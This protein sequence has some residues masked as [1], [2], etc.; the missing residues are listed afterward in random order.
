[1]GAPDQLRFTFT[2]S[3]QNSTQIGQHVSLNYCALIS[4]RL[5][6]PFQQ[7]LYFALISDEI[8]VGTRI[9]SL[10]RPCS[11]GFVCLQMMV[12]ELAEKN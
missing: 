4:G 8:G 7:K 6:C 2:H 1:M 12:P 11:A 5:A 10:A 3:S 9:R